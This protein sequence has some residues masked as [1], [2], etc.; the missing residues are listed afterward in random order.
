MFSG[1]FNIIAFNKIF[2]ELL[3]SIQ[4]GNPLFTVSNYL[5][6]KRLSKNNCPA[7]YISQL[8]PSLITTTSQGLGRGLLQW[9]LCPVGKIQKL[10]T[11]LILDAL[12]TMH[13]IS[14]YFIDP[15]FIIHISSINS[16]LPAT[17]LVLF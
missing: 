8:M 6:G 10:K 7:V 2:I 16:T 4:L 11:T 13:H 5:S 17:N 3:S 12:C 1:D 9:K 15:A 14:H